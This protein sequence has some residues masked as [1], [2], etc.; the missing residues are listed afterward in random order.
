MSTDKN[1]SSFPCTISEVFLAGLIQG[2]G[3]G[4]TT[5]IEEIQSMLMSKEKLNEESEAREKDSVLNYQMR[6]DWIPF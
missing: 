3:T 1:I 2:Q 4:L 6:F 5:N